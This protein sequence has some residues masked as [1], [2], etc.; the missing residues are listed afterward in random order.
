[1]AA[2]IAG[3]KEVFE[4]QSARMTLAFSIAT[5]RRALAPLVALIRE[6]KVANRANACRIVTTMGGKD[7]M[8]FVFSLAAKNSN[9][10]LLQVLA[11]VSLQQQGGPDG[12]QCPRNHAAA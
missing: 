2:R 8:T 10:E 7:E 11:D 5:D 9:V 1:M 3:G 12:H 6:G 4:G